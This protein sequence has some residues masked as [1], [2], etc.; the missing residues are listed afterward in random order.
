[1]K[2]LLKAD[3]RWSTYEKEKKVLSDRGS[4]SRITSGK[5]DPVIFE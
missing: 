3:P 2:A 1:M 5:N 4:T